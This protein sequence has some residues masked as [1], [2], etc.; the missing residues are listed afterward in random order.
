MVGVCLDQRAF[1]R[2]RFVVKF[3]TIAIVFFNLSALAQVYQYAP[4]A[5]YAFQDINSVGRVLSQY[6]FIEFDLKRKGSVV[7]S[8]I[9]QIYLN[10]KSKSELAVLTLDLSLSSKEKILKLSSSEFVC[11]SQT[12]TGRHFALYVKGKS[13]RETNEICHKLQMGSS[14]SFARSV[15]KPFNYLSQI[16]IA[17][18]SAKED[19]APKNTTLAAIGE[20]STELNESILVQRLG[21]CL[22]HTLNGA[23]GSA[24]GLSDQLKKTFSALL[25]N[26]RELWNEISEQATALKEFVWHIKTEVMQL[27]QALQEADME[28]LMDVGCQFAGEFLVTT[29]LSALTGAGLVKLSLGFKNMFEKLK[30][31]KTL[32]AR[33]KE[34]KSKGKGQLAKGVLSCAIK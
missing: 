22:S 33:L 32:F 4:R 18:A 19:C 1:C 21:T 14:N 26:P 28:M 29:G 8:F 13:T 34:L 23:I 15:F 10:P 7:E 24:Q 5:D 2:L 25:K 17:E 9:D 12:S 6:G 11:H 27:K 31:S 3:I 30:N 16:F 20:L